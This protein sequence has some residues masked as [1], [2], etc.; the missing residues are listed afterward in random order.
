MLVGEN[1]DVPVKDYQEVANLFAV[2]TIP[3][4][5]LVAINA[6]ITPK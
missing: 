5:S 1:D 6:G 4:L 2:T 3:L